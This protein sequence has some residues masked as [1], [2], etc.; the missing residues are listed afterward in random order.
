[1]AR[2]TLLQAALQKVL[3]K[4][5]EDQARWCRQKL[6]PKVVQVFPSADACWPFNRKMW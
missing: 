5:D 6:S 3:R 1:M 2:P 4:Q